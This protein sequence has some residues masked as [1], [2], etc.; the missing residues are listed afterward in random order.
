MT[1]RVTHFPLRKLDRDA[2]TKYF[3][4]PERTHREWESSHKFDFLYRFYDSDQQPL[5]IG[6]TAGGGIRW[7]QHRKHSE[8]W[9]LAEYVAVSFYQSYEAVKVAEKA[10]IRSE[11]PRF[12]K[13]FLRGP[14]NAS[15]HLHGHAEDAAAL[16][17]RDAEPEFIASLAALLTQPE[18]FP[19]PEPPPPAAFADESNQL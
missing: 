11:Q 8:W 1:L 5:Y 18:R 16:L 2:P 7:D 12:N 13:L 17:F 6:I 19:Q 14:A 15:L 9:P 3:Q 4:A 10:A